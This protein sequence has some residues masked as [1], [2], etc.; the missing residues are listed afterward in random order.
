MS[1]ARKRKE[2]EEEREIKYKG[3]MRTGERCKEEKTKE[4]LRTGVK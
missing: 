2:E 1:R 4:K 3:I